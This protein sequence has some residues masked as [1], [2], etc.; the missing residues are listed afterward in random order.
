MS[1]AKWVLVERKLASI[2]GRMLEH[3]AFLMT[4][5]PNPGSVNYHD[6][7]QKLQGF[8]DELEMC[9]KQIKS[10]L[11]F[12]QLKM[13]D[14]WKA[15]HSQRYRIKQSVKSTEKSWA[16]AHAE[17]MRIYSLLKAMC[18]DFSGPDGSSIHELLSNVEKG[19][20]AVTLDRSHD[21]GLLEVSALESPVVNVDIAALVTLLILMMQHV[22]ERHKNKAQD[23]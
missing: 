5:G 6:D 11:H 1:G 4:G 21:S 7:W 12:N 2:Y 3:P 13:G 22:V 16:P 9:L 20:E 19:I 14:Y 8:R 15:S 23:T 18:A 10:A 17:A